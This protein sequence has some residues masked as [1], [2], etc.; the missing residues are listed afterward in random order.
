MKCK[1]CHKGR[2][3]EI[4]GKIFCTE[5]LRR[6]CHRCHGPI[7]RTQ[8]LHETGTGCDH[9]GGCPGTPDNGKAY[10]GHPHNTAGTVEMGLP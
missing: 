1:I 5:C 3:R 6:R 8:S 7:F 2:I 10:I 9:L 4:R